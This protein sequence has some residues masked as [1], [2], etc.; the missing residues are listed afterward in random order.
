MTHGCMC[1]ISVT[2][3]QVIDTKARLSCQR[4]S[5]AMIHLMLLKSVYA[6]NRVL[7]ASG[8]KH[9]LTCMLVTVCW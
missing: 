5:T 3:G 6:C 9:T 1:S 7:V 2:C 8:Y 4:S